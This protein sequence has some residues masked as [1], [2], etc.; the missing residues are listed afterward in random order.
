MQTQS[1]YMD[2]FD[3]TTEF[4]MQLTA[5]VRISD[6]EIDLPVDIFPGPKSP[7][8]SIPRD[9]AS[10]FKPNNPKAWKTPA[11]WVE[12]TREARGGDNAAEPSNT[13][14]KQEGAAESREAVLH[15]MRQEIKGMALADPPTILR[16]LRDSSVPDTSDSSQ[17]KEA[18]NKKKR[19]MLSVVYNL[20]GAVK[21]AAMSSDS[22]EKSQR[23]V[24]ALL[25]SPC[26]HLYHRRSKDETW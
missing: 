4:S 10:S 2:V 8:R 16:H 14:T 5:V 3:Q 20:D 22:E 18:E 7:L 24:L 11:E 23:R 15:R 6:D 21:M 9:W 26:K 1:K 25:E 13:D 17:Y 12:A 19:W